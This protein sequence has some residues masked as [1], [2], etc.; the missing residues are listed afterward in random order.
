MLL[1]TH[2]VFS[3]LLYLL[4]FNFISEKLIFL[5]FLVIGTAIV[6]IDTKKSKLGKKWFFRPLQLFVKHRRIFHS[7]FLCFGLSFIVYYF[8]HSAG[9]GIFTGYFSHLFL[10]CFTKQGVKLFSPLSDFRIRFLLKTGGLIEEILF[11][12]LLLTDFFLFLRIAL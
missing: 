12:I 10:D 5:L 1:R 6:D 8:N 9:L 7:L 11:V 4:L 3:A 2:L